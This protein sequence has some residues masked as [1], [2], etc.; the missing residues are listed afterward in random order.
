MQ[1]PTA[2]SQ[3]NYDGSLKRVPP[4]LLVTIP[5][6]NEVENID[7]FVKTVFDY[8]PKNAEIL[9]IDDN[10]P[11][12]TARCVEKLIQEYPSR[13]HLMKRPEKQ[14]G[15]SAFLQ[16]FSWGLAHGFD[17][18]LAMDADFSHDPQHIP[19]FLEKSKNT[20]M[21]I[22]SRLITGGRIENRSFSR[23]LLSKGASFYCRVLL[24][25]QIHDWTGGY[26]LWSKKA[27]ETIGVESI[28]TRGYSFQLEMKYKALSRG[29]T[30]AEIPIVFPERKHGTSK[31]PPS[32]LVKALADVWRIRF[33]CVNESLQ[34][35]FKFVITGGLGTITNLLIF[36]LCA[37]KFGL[38][39]IPVSI[40]CFL[41]A[42]TQNYVINHRWSFARVSDK[43][44]LSIK[45]WFAFLCASLLGLAV[46]IVVMRTIIRSFVLPYK[47]IAQ[48]CGILCG[49]IINFV[50]SKFVVFKRKNE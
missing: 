16:A 37:D 29:C 26:N 13:L 14:G 10:S 6:Y 3:H 33:M 46:N 48:A 23:D 43:T 9:V 32:F 38:P 25:S 39:E 12:G 8:I 1:Q 11:D 19:Q 22:G 4:H 34:Q 50:V 18:M 42:G 44:V 15:A 40:G 47:S 28:A 5:T 17:S 35:F 20:D 7:M 2:N 31:M 45:K 27:L 49:M 30:V 24:G 41:A 36:F 21:V